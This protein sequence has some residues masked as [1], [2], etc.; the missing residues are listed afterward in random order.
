MGAHFTAV[1]YHGT[2]DAAQAYRTL[3]R[4]AQDQHGWDPYSGTIATAGGFT[5]ADTA[6]LPPA[7]A[8]RLAA[9]AA[10]GLRKRGPWLAVPVAQAETT[11]VTV[12]VV[13]RGP[14]ALHATAA[15]KAARRG[16]QPASSRVVRWERALGAPRVTTSRRTSPVWVVETRPEQ[17]FATRAEAIAAA[18]AAVACLGETAGG[19]EWGLSTPRV[20]VSRQYR[21]ADGEFYPVVVTAPTKRVAATVEVTLERALPGGRAGWL[22]A[23]WAAT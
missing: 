22:F 21:D 7:A 1:R 8:D 19:G 16:W 18:R 12:D 9:A 6:P 5:L 2:A 23:G 17:I 11:K 10:D 3:V 14:D 20:T 4:D 15:A 13:L